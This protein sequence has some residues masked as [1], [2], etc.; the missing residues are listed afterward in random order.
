MVSQSN[1]QHVELRQPA[2]RRREEETTGHKEREK[3]AHWKINQEV[4]MQ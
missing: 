4:E 2:D 3:A 1:L